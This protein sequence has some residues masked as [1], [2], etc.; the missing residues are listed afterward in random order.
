MAVFLI[1]I[2]EG[3][4]MIFRSV[5]NDYFQNSSAVFTIPDIDNGFIPQGIDYDPNTN[6]FFVTGYMGNGKSSPIYAIEKGSGEVKQKVLMTTFDG[7]DF[8]GHSGGLSVI[9][10]RL[11]IAGSTDACIYSFR[12]PDILDAENNSKVSASET[13][14]LKT[15][16]DFI[17]VSFTS[18]NNSILYGGEYHQSP[19]FYTHKS[20]FVNDNGKFQKAYLFGF[21]LD[22]DQHVIP[23]HVYSIPDKI[24]GAFFDQGYLFLSQSNGLLP[25]RILA[26]DLS[27]IEP[28]GNRNVLGKDVPLYIIS[29][30]NAVKIT[31]IPPMPEEIVVIENHMYILHEAASNR[32]LIGKLLGQK[33]VYST[34]IRFF[35]D[36]P[37]KKTLDF[38]N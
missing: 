26:Y 1:G 19:I 14:G 23:S 3:I 5:L 11:Y 18:R 20:H 34:P 9:K 4:F 25:G 22:I 36:T 28:S 35:I 29:E 8:K 12:V 2:A 10:D 16:D 38:E 33:K 24:Q 17:R 21:S 31:T 32:Y 15:D 37:G 27:M 6:Y 7:K 13:I 30:N